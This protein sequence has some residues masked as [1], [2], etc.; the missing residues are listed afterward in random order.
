MKEL[1]PNR[2][3]VANTEVWKNKSFEEW[4]KPVFNN[5]SELICLNGNCPH[6]DHSYDNTYDDPHAE[7]LLKSLKSGQRMLIQTDYCKTDHVDYMTLDH[8]RTHSDGLRQLAFQEKSN[9]CYHLKPSPY[10]SFGVTVLWSSTRYIALADNP[11][12]AAFGKYGGKPLFSRELAKLTGVSMR[13]VNGAMKELD[14]LNNPLDLPIRLKATNRTW[15]G[16]CCRLFDEG[17]I[18]EF[19]NV[20]DNIMQVRIPDTATTIGIL[21]QQGKIDQL[22]AALANWHAPKADELRSA[23]QK[24]ATW[25]AKI[26]PNGETQT[27]AWQKQ[28][29]EMIHV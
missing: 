2:V 20:F 25:Y 17:K 23:L 15:I 6:R 4:H 1:E 22:K 12:E 24:F 7:P 28:W 13:E 11:S 27:K 14:A 18:S 21:T 16:T 19:V 26:A 9:D 10:A 3:K 29:D 5:Q 8:V